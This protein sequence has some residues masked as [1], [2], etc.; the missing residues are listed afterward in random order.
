[1]RQ[2][3]LSVIGF[4]IL[5]GGCATTA[6][7]QLRVQHLNPEGL[8]KNP[9]F[10][11]A[12]VVQSSHST[13]YVGEQNAVDASGKVVGEGDLA[14]QVTQVLANLKAALNAGGATLQDVVS[15]RLYLVQGQSLQEGY[16]AFQ[17][18]WGAAPNPPTIS[19]QFVSGLAH[20]EYLVG[21]EAVAVTSRAASASQ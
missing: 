14:A 12:V 17:K 6:G 11:Q 20:P 5:L 4:S 15:W 19:F 9:A 18:E 10:S 7:P 8:P 1:M 21:M 3:A 2:T 16:K 13:V